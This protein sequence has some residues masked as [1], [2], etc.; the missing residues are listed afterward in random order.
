MEREVPPGILLAALAI[1]LAGC[2]TAPPTATPP[3][4]PTA[5]PTPTPTPTP[6]SQ[7]TKVTPLVWP[8]YTPVITLPPLPPLGDSITGTDIL[9]GSSTPDCQLP[10]WR[11]LVIDRSGQDDIQAMYEE[12]FGIDETYDIFGATTRSTT[13]PGVFEVSLSQ[14]SESG[15]YLTVNAYVSKETGTLRGLDIAWDD[16]TIG[17]STTP[18]RVIRELGEPLLMLAA[19][20]GMQGHIDPDHDPGWLH[21]TIVYK[22]G[23]AFYYLNKVIIQNRRSANRIVE[24]S[25]RF[26]LSEN[27]GVGSVNLMRPLAGG[28]DSLTPYQ[29]LSIVTSASG[30]ELR[31][32]QEI[33]NVSL[34][35]VTELALQGGDACLYTDLMQIEFE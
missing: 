20:H 18:L 22:E 21:L 19:V 23:I 11:G 10:C 33:F 15:N 30:V 7:P 34:A 35:E 25:V 27:D 14:S 9:F 28:L 1:A 12:V 16:L 26:C 24:R 32:L 31:P 4:A 17:E 8:T 29:E 2:A 13:I 6:T 3:P 5:T